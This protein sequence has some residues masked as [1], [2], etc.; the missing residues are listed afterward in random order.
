MAPHGVGSSSPSALRR[1][2]ISAAARV[3]PG[4]KALY[5][6]ESAV[7]RKA[8]WDLSRERPTQ[9]PPPAQ[10]LGRPSARLRASPI[11]FGVRGLLLLW[12]QGCLIGRAEPRLAPNSRRLS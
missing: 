7:E 1:R 6:A 11:S 9:L 10:R 3:R 8:R 4:V 5:W 12:P 2:V